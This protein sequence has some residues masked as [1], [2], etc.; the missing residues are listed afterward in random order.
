MYRSDTPSTR[1]SNIIHDKMTQAPAPTHTD[2]YTLD[3]TDTGMFVNNNSSRYIQFELMRD[4]DA[5]IRNGY[6]WDHISKEVAFHPDKVY[7]SNSFIKIGPQKVKIYDN[8]RNVDKII[9]LNT[10]MTKPLSHANEVCLDLK[11]I[12]I[13]MNK[14][15]DYEARFK[16]DAELLIIKEKYNLLQEKLMNE[17]ES[18]LNNIVL[19]RP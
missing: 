18:N 13:D 12:D 2:L 14:D 9:P 16:N 10:D 15:F 6:N 8:K 5:L 7:E 3:S 1:S 11:Q 4:Y 19:N 17:E